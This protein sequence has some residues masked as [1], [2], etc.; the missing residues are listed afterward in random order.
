MPFR[1]APAYGAIGWQ[2]EHERVVREHRVVAKRL[3]E[4][5][6]AANG[7]ANG[8]LGGSRVAAALGGK[9]RVTARSSASS[10]LLATG[11]THA[12]SRIDGRGSP[13]ASVKEPEQLL[14]AMPAASAP[15]PARLE[16]L[17][18]AVP[19]AVPLVA[20]A[21][22]ADTAEYEAYLDDIAQPDGQPG[23]QLGTGGDYGPRC[24]YPSRS[25]PSVTPSPRAFIFSVENA[26]CR[27]LTG[28]NIG[29]IGFSGHSQH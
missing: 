1:S 12:R 7:L 24:A 16:E 14:R 18:L 19:R 9:P 10:R 29:A 13:P 21:D 25:R 5:E 27:I 3:A 28:V 23:G 26:V 4:H 15:P 2:V 22:A 11:I 8:G 17:L 6:T 20:V